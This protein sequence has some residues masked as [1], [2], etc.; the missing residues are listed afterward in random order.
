MNRLYPTQ[1]VKTLL[2]PLH[3]SKLMF[4]NLEPVSRLKRKL[5]VNSVIYCFFPLRDFVCCADCVD[6]P[7]MLV[8]SLCVLGE[9]WVG[10]DGISVHCTLTRW[11][12]AGAFCLA[13]WSHAKVRLPQ[14]SECSL[15]QAFRLLVCQSNVLHRS[16][17]LLCLQWKFT[18]YRVRTKSVP[19]LFF[20]IKLFYLCN[21]KITYL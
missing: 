21:K 10:G 2:F 12:S 20:F 8:A 15:S 7:L 6:W 14:Q 1:H 13:L 5:A 18:S 11:V 9:Q 16:Y 4:S 19:L 17:V 3:K